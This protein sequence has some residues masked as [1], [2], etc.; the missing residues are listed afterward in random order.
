MALNPLVNR[1]VAKMELRNPEL[2]KEENVSQS[3]MKMRAVLRKT[4]QQPLPQHQVLEADLRNTSIQHRKDMMIV[5]D[6]DHTDKITSNL[7]HINL[8]H[9]AV[10]AAQMAMDRIHIKATGHLVTAATE[11]VIVVVTLHIKVTEHLVMDILMGVETEEEAVQMGMAHIRATGLP[12]TDV[13]GMEMGARRQGL[14]IELLH[15]ME[16]VRTFLSVAL[17][18]SAI[19]FDSFPERC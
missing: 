2:V 15:T 11:V 19:V 7:L 17:N 13:M 1:A 9:R 6:M 3:I 4:T 8:I 18:Y 12:V 14:I 10:E 5:K 16:M